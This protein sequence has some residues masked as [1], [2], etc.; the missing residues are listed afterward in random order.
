MKQFFGGFVALWA[1]LCCGNVNAACVGGGTKTQTVRITPGQRVVSSP[2]V[3]SNTITMGAGT[4]TVRVNTGGNNPRYIGGTPTVDVDV[5]APND[6]V[7]DDYVASG[8]SGGQTYSRQAYVPRQNY[9]P[10]QNYV[11]QQ[12]YRQ[13]TTY[14][15]PSYSNQP[16]NYYRG[17]MT[18]VTSAPN[19]T[20]VRYANGPYYQQQP[21]QQRNVAP[22]QTQSEGHVS[23]AYQ[24]N[25]Y[26]Y[27]Y[28]GMHLDLNLFNWRNTYKA[29]PVAANEAFNHDDYKFKPV[30][31][32]HF[33]AGYRF[34]PGWRADAEFGFTSNYT[35]ADN[36]I[37]FELSVPY[38][39]AN[40]YHDFVNGLYLGLGAGAAFP[41]ISMEWENFTA[42]SSHKTGASFTG[43]AMVGYSY[44][45]SKSL[46]LDFRYRFS[47]F[48]GTSIKRGVTGHSVIINDSEVAL[49]S[50]ETKVGFVIDN[51]ISLGLKYE[52]TP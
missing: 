29:L 8:R 16:N 28:V 24:Y 3:V 47:G 11:P 49:Q 40:I 6:Y 37:S 1:G 18:P 30:I 50:L 38:V 44:Y 5:R 52:E 4:P 23:K 9:A 7:V 32:G 13:P 2:Q 22:M 15:R 19:S 25:K 10:Q 14:Q 42:N 41:T 43:A 27:G 48:N 21:Q 33:V 39:T 36:G 34:S 46:I 35:D 45:L 20:P 26:G 51:T 17:N 12:T 31:G